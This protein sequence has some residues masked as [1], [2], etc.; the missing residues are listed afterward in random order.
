MIENLQEQ[1]QL[2]AREA[3]E[4][5]G[6]GYRRLLR[7]QKRAGAGAPALCTAETKF[8]RED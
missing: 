6:L 2:S 4:A 8:A 1:S 3:S 7:W 5:L